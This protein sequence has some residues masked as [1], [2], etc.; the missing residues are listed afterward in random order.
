[1]KNT[2]VLI[3]GSGISGLFFAIKTAMVRPDLSITIMTKSTAD[4]SNTRFAQGGIA[5]VTDLMKDSFDQHIED[6]IKAGGGEGDRSVIEMV[7]RQAPDRLQE[8]LDFEVSFD[9]KVS[10][11]WD[12][13]L[14]G[15]HSQHRILHHKDLTGLEIQEK[16][17]LRVSRFPNVKLMEETQA[18]DLITDEKNG[19]KRCAGVIYFN[20]DS[21]TTECILAKIIV[22]STGGCG[23]I[24]KNTTNPLIATG[25]GVAMA[26]RA[27]AAIK[28]LQYIQFHPT[29]LYEKDRNL[30]FLISEAVRGFGAY[31]VDSI[32]ERFLFEYDPRGEMATRDIVSAAIGQE[33]SRSGGSNVYMDCRHLDHKDFYKHFPT[34]TDYCKNAGI[35]ISNA[36][37][38]IVPVAHYQCGGIQV[39]KD[40][41]STIRNLFAVGECACTGLHGRN[42]LASNSLLEA[43]VYAHQSSE[44]I[45]RNIDSVSNPENYKLKSIPISKEKNQKLETMKAE[46]KAA[47][48]A[49]FLT[50]T[51]ASRVKNKMGEIR[52]GL[53]VFPTEERQSISFLEFQNMLDTAELILEEKQDAKISKSTQVVATK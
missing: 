4:Y 39:N 33:I 48:S 45:C 5:V 10:G 42:R 28:D 8:L 7:V 17:L 21:S 18:L 16:M 6:T 27:G 3:V 37:I 41:Q 31:V 23:Q 50:D 24:F 13:G 30:N 26:Y 22:L 32:G 11:E 52:V 35:D 43:L 19:E 25:D 9:K 20:K 36:L 49:L 12:L 46:M 2:D 47:M 40:G 53:N 51:M 38:P 15:G 44:F 1:M 29:A 34:I 14:E